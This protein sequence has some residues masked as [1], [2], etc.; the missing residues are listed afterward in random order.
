MADMFS[1][2]RCLGTLPLSYARFPRR[3]DSNPRLPAYQAITDSH[4][5]RHQVYVIVADGYVAETGCPNH[6]GATSIRR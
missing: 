2:N 4:P 6:P 5:T 3:R 1:E